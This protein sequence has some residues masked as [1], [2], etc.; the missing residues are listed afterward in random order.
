MKRIGIDLE[1]LMTGEPYPHDHVP[2]CPGAAVRIT[3][4]DYDN[5]VDGGEYF[6]TERKD[7]PAD[8]YGTAR[9]SCRMPVAP[10]VNT[11]TRQRL[12][13]GLCHSC[14]VL[15]ARNREVLRARQGG[16]ARREDERNAA[17]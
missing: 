14:S 15:E 3:R 10:L 4:K 8:G 6:V 12:Y 5:M 9:V 16:G 17:E 1:R 11:Q 13:Y 2:D 7:L